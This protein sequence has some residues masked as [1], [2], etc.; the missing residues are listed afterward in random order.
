MK[1]PIKIFATNAALYGFGSLI[2]VFRGFAS[3][4]AWAAIVLGY[5]LLALGLN[6]WI[7]AAANRSPMQFVTAVNGSTAL[8][9][10]SSLAGVLLYLVLVGG[11]FRVHFVLGLFAAFALNTALLVVESQKLSSKG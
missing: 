3:T 11:E 8:K 9:M 5:S 2:P 10:F 1:F 6:R 7:T 4:W